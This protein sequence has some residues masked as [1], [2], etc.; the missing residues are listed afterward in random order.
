MVEPTNGFLLSSTSAKLTSTAGSK[1]TINITAN[2]E[3]T[4]IS[5]Q[6][7]LTVNQGQSTDEKIL[8]FTAQA[9]VSPFIRKATVTISAADIKHQSIVI[10]QDGSNLI[11]NINPGDLASKLTPEELQTVT[12][13]TLTGTIDARDFK[14]LRDQM[15]LL[16]ELDLGDVTIAKYTGIEGTYVTNGNFPANSIPD[17][18]FYPSLNNDKTNIL[19]LVLPKSLPQINGHA[20]GYKLVLVSLTM[21]YPVPPIVIDPNIWTID[22]NCTLYVPY[23]AANRYKIAEKW[24]EFTSIVEA[25]KGFHLSNYQPILAGEEGSTTTVNVTS[26]IEWNVTSNQDWLEISPVFGNGNQTLTFTAKAN[27]LF[28]ARTAIVTISGQGVSPQTITVTQNFQI[29][30][31]KTLEVTPGAL[32]T[33]L[34]TDELNTISKL[35]LTGSIDARDFKTLRDKMP[36]LAELDLSGARIVAYNGSEGTYNWSGNIQY[37]ANTIPVSAFSFYN[38]SD[39]KYY[40]KVSLRSV[41]IPT[42]TIT[43]DDSAFLGCQGLTS[44]S[45]PSSITSINSQAFRDC[46]SLSSINIP[47]SVNSIDGYAY[48]NCIKLTSIILNWSIPLYK[49]SNYYN[50]F[51]GFDKTACTLYVPYG[52][53]STYA[54]ANQWKDFKNIKEMPGFMPLTFVAEIASMQGSAASVTINSDVSWTA[55][56]DQAWL[57][58]SPTSGTGLGQKL[59]FTAEANAAYSPR[60]AKV[61]VSSDGIASQVITITQ[62]PAAAKVEMNAGSLATAFTEEELKNIKELTLTGTIDARDFKTMR[63]KMPLLAKI[64]ISA[65]TIVA[66]MGQEGTSSYRSSYYA[67]TLPEMAF[68]NKASLTSI[69]LSNS[70]TTVETDAFNQCIG[71]T[72]IIIPEGVTRIDAKAFYKCTGLKTAIIPSSIVSLQSASFADCTSLISLTVN[73]SIPPGLSLY[74]YVFNRVDK[75]AC[76]LNVPYA[77]RQNYQKAYQWNEFF[78]VVEPVNGFAISSNKVNVAGSA[79]SKGTVSVSANIEWTAS[80]DQEW[81]SVNPILGSDNQS[82]IFTAQANPSFIATRT[83][84]VTVSTTVPGVASQKIT[85]TQNIHPQ[86]PKALEMTPGALAAA[87]TA[88]ELATITDLTLTGSIDARDFKT[89]RDRMPLLTNVNLSEAT[90]VAYNGTEGT[91]NV[92]HTDY[93]A[94][95]IPEFA[96]VPKSMNIQGESRLTSI[97]FPESLTAI[98]QRAFAQCISLANVIITPSVTTIGDYAFYGCRNITEMT[99]PAAVSSIGMRAF[100]N[101][102]CRFDVDPSNL[103]YMSS[104]NVLFNKDQTVLIQCVAS[105]TGT[106]EIPPTV[107]TIADYAFLDRLSMTSLV[108]PSSLTSIGKYAFYNCYKLATVSIPSSVTFIGE[109]AFA[110]CSRLG[111]IYAHSRIPINLD[112]SPYVFAGLSGCKL[113]VPEGSLNAYRTASQWKDFWSIY[114]TK[115][116]IANAGPDQVTNEGTLVTLDGFVFLNTSGKPLTYQ[117]IAPEGIAL[118]STTE[119]KPTFTAPEVINARNLTFSLVI[120]DGTNY[121]LADEVNIYVNNV[122]K[123]PVAHAGADQTV[124]ENTLVTLDGSASFDPDGHTLN[125]EWITPNGIILSSRYSSKATFTAQ[126]VFSDTMFTFYLR[127]Y[128]GYS[129]QTDTVVITVKHVNKIPTANAGN[130]QYTEEGEVVQL[131]GSS[132]WAP[133]G[134]TLTYLWTAPEGIILNSKTSARPSFT[135][136]EVDTDTDFTFTLTVKDKDNNSSTAE[137]TVRVRSVSPVLK[138]ISNANHQPMPVYIHYKLFKKEADSFIQKTDTFGV[139]GEVLYLTLEAGEWIALALPARDPSAFIPTYSGDV[140]TWEEATIINLLDKR[141]EYMEINCMEASA[142][143]EGSGQI[144]GFVYEKALGGTKSISLLKEQNMQFASPVFNALVRLYKKDNPVPVASVYT[145]SQGAYQFDKL[146]VDN[147]E[148]VVEIPGFIQSDK[149]IVALSTSAPMAKAYFAVDTS[150]QVIT[151]NRSWKL[152]LLKVYPN[153]TKG[154]VHISG[155]PE[156]EE[157]SVSVYTMDGRTVVASK[158][159]TEGKIDLSNQVPGIYLMMVNKERFKIIKK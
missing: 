99:I 61:T 35:T 18:S 81:L 124:N 158:P 75:N 86:P 127:V 141:V 36:V 120:S 6:S 70:I 89:M 9:N 101:L 37:A 126:D 58:V 44:F 97:T 33:L 109:S 125:Y 152:S 154:V 137:V 43:I 118:S 80:S 34:N 39:G 91:S 17:F 3:L 95:T 133:D 60:V 14:T 136:P 139:T 76:V 106:Y 140:L 57:T 69:L 78:N 16:T 94:N 119:L 90:I 144:S 2:V 156:N 145:D 112:A 151:D 131:D 27:Q 25:E 12:N 55:S 142:A 130:N 42:T 71:L 93:P 92:G 135:A 21:D 4:A 115:E 98:G 116:L 157:N 23:G 74:S 146:A 87:L 85:I 134:G 79:G 1:T 56:S 65:A 149:F 47:S 19:S 102:D 132:S 13:L 159:L 50:I 82:I 105:V 62:S 96:F 111:T 117:W 8:I 31:L 11:L 150:L 20:F 40:G 138:L 155:L 84:I 38:H 26:N 143:T 10:T 45:I 83:A 51:D 153:P 108:I 147:Y 88:D 64:D 68:H 5:D 107:T 148:I 22:S 7:W 48:L 66:Y 72:N 32:S 15:P 128:D 28:A 46:T 41:V 122:N 129:Y 67:N 59:T 110:S 24:K 114:E 29:Q 53:S 103:H 49:P 100:G 30:P 121:S 63:D 77:S 52:T 113:Y 73:T 104:N 123:A 54:S